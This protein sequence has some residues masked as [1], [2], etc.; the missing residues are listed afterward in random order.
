MEKTV[1]ILTAII[2]YSFIS[3]RTRVICVDGRKNLDAIDRKLIPFVAA[4]WPIF[5][6]FVIVNEIVGFFRRILGK[7]QRGYC[8]KRKQAHHQERLKRMNK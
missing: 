4:L 2:I 8:R 3:W 7:F 5:W 1:I 6:G